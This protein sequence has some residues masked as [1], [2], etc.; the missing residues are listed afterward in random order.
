MFK[1][2]CINN[3]KLIE[4]TI[5]IYRSFASFLS[6]Y[7]IPHIYFIFI[8]F[9]KFLALTS[10]QELYAFFIVINENL[11]THNHFKLNLT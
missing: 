6:T 7:K 2:M 11:S 5:S 4:I 3:M 8:V 10:K 1:K 9:D